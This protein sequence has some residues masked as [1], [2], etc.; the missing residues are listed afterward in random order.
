MSPLR[1]TSSHKARPVL[2]ID[3]TALWH[4]KTTG[5]QR[6]IRETTPYLAAAAAERGWEIVLVRKIPQG[7]AE[8]TRWRSDFEPGRVEVDL[9]RIAE[10]WS[11]GRA[12]TLRPG[13]AF[14][15]P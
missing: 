4:Q 14:R 6:V 11:D 5:I 9:N 3:M 2:A 8:I 15:L 1:K 7:L 10:G 13:V 12:S